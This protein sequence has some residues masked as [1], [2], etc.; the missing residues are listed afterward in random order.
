MRALLGGVCVF[1]L[2]GI[3]VAGLWPFNPRPANKVKWLSE[4]NGLEFS[5]DG[6]VFTEEPFHIWASPAEQVS[7]DVWLQPATDDTAPILCFYKRKPREE[8]RLL[9]YGDT[10]LLQI[11]H[12]PD[13]AAL[14]IEHVLHPR[15][16]TFITIALDPQ[17]TAVYV[18]GTL[19]KTSSHFIVMPWDLS[20]Q[21]VAGTQPFDYDSWAGQLRALAIYHQELT[22]SH[23]RARYQSWVSGKASANPAP[24][25]HNAL[26]LY[27]F[28]EHHGK[29]VHNAAALGP[30]LVI[31]DAFSILEKKFLE[32]PWSSAALDWAYFQDIAINIAGF[33]P[34]GFFVCAFLNS[35]QR[36]RRLSAPLAA[37]AIGIA[38]SLTIEILQFS[39]PTRDSSLT[40][41][42]TNTLG[43]VMGVALYRLKF[44][45]AVL[46]KVTA[47]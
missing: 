37:I 25:L 36:P 18:N 19:A 9:Q 28:D 33:V 41:V 4:E 14:E 40:D 11:K 12:G 23:A 20:G 34:L 10:L 43:T 35:G 46:A 15:Q 24:D 47:R 32:P 38:G 2:A 6:I 21:F 29:R 27:R 30:N 3:L 8:F 22:A 39:L 45:Q 5:R 17:Q 1:I 26:A 44:T 16:S 42:I 7:L 13:L 31:P